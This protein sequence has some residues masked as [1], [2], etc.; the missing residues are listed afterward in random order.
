MKGFVDD[1]EVRTESNRDFRRVLYTGP[2]LQLVVMSLEPGVEIGEETHEDTD[3]FFRLET[4]EGE[5]EIDGRVTKIEGDFGIVV[6]AGARHN[7]RNTGQEPLKLYTIY[8][9][10]HHADGTVQHTK[11]EADASAEHFS[12]TTTE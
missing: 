4:G 5:V 10:P 12:G 1:I 11:A 3:Q 9:P 7:V 8:A 6:P 2:H